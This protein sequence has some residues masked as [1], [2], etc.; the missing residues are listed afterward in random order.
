VE[1]GLVAVEM[2]GSG[3]MDEWIDGW[4]SGK[5]CWDDP[6]TYICIDLSS[7]TIFGLLDGGLLVDGQVQPC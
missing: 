3:L 6:G 7:I 2:D 5:Q 4:M 1:K